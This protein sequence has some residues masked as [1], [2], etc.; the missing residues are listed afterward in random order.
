MT[1]LNGD[2]LYFSRSLIPNDIAG[3]YPHMK[4]LGIYAFRKRFL[5][6]IPQLRKTEL[7]KAERLEQLRILANGYKIRVIETSRDSIAV[8]TAEDLKALND[9]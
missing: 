2:A 1:D 9:R 3:S 4:H 7:E 5:G 8:D 6:I